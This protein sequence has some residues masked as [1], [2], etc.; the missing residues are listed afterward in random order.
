MLHHAACYTILV[1]HVTI[2]HGAHPRE[3]MR[4]IVKWRIATHVAKEVIRA[5]AFMNVLAVLA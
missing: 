5:F 3:M 2:H 4:V 1:I